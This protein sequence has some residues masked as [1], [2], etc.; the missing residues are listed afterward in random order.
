[1]YNSV[2]NYLITLKSNPDVIRAKAV[3]GSQIVVLN[4]A[5]YIQN[6]L[7]LINVGPYI[8]TH[9]NIYPFNS[10][11]NKIKTIVESSPLMWFL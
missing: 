10:E 2:K 8:Y 5:Y 7:K 6:V 11:L 4:K 9:D 3:K 1:M